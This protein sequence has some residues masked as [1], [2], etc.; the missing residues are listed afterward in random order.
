M[1]NDAQAPDEA[2]PP[3]AD[4]VTGATAPASTPPTPEQLQSQGDAPENLPESVTTSQRDSRFGLHITE[5][6]RKETLLGSGAL[7]NFGAGAAA[8]RALRGPQDTEDKEETK[9]RLLAYKLM[10]PANSAGDYTAAITGHVIGGLMTPEAFL[11]PEIKL[12]T[13]AWRLAH[14]V[15]Q[16]IFGVGT[17]QGL[18]NMATDP[19]VQYHAISAGV[20]EHY[21]W[22]RTAL[23]FPL[24]FVT[25]S[26]FQSLSEMKR[27]LTGHLTGRPDLP[28]VPPAP[29]PPRVWTPEAQAVPVERPPVV[30]PE[31]EIGSSRNQAAESPLGEIRPAEEGA[32]TADAGRTEPGA[33]TAGEPRAEPG[34]SPTATEG[35][36]GAAPAEPARVKPDREAGIEG[37]EVAPEL[38]GSRA[39]T[40]PEIAQGRREPT[41]PEAATTTPGERVE[42]I[43]SPQQAMRRLADSLETVISDEKL[44]IRGAEGEYDTRTAT[45]RLKN[46]T[47][48]DVFTHEIGHHVEYRIGEPLREI[49]RDAMA[50]IGHLVPPELRAQFGPEEMRAEAFAEYMN[51]FLLSEGLAQREAPNFTRS[52]TTFMRERYPGVLLEI[53]QFRA[54]YNAWENA[55][56]GVALKATIIHPT[57][58]AAA[59][60]R[61]TGNPMERGAFGEFLY[62]LRRQLFDRA[63]AMN[64]LVRKVAE[65]RGTI[66]A[67]EDNPALLLRRM[68][69]AAQRSFETDMNV[70]IGGRPHE[71]RV[72]NEMVKFSPN[73]VVEGFTTTRGLY[74]H[75]LASEADSYLRSRRALSLLDEYRNGLR[76][77]RPD[78]GTYADHTSEVARVEAA[79]PEFKNFAEM[80]SVIHADDV[81]RK[82]SGGLITTEQRDALLRNKTYV[83]FQ[84]D[85]RLNEIDLGGATGGPPA[86]QALGA[87]QIQRLV[88]SDRDIISPLSSFVEQMLTTN[89]RLRENEW[90]NS[91][92]RVIRELGPDGAYVGE[93]VPI[94]KTTGTQVDVLEAIGKKLRE[95]GLPREDIDAQL[96]TLRDAFSGADNMTTL[97]RTSERG[98]KDFA[99]TVILTRENGEVKALVLRDTQFARDLH[100]A[101]Q[102]TGK[103]MGDMITRF[104]AHGSNLLRVGATGN[105]TFAVKNLFVD[106]LTRVLTDFRIGRTGTALDF[107]PGLPALKSYAV[108]LNE[109]LRIAANDAFEKI[110][111]ANALFG[112][113]TPLPTRGEPSA[114]D[115]ERALL[116]REGLIGQTYW[117]QAVQATQGYSALGHA[118][119]ETRLRPALEIARAAIRGRERGDVRAEIGDSA[120]YIR[121]IAAEKYGPDAPALGL[122]IA[123]DYVLDAAKLATIDPLKTGFGLF[124]YIAEI[125]EP[126][127]RMA[128][129]REILRYE[130]RAA[131]VSATE[132]RAFY[133][134]PD[135]VSPEV[136]G[137]IIGAIH[138]AVAGSN[139][140]ADF[141][142]SGQ[143]M[144]GLARLTP[145]F[146]ANVQG[147]AA[148]GETLKFLTTTIAPVTRKQ[149]T[150]QQNR[151]YGLWHISALMAGSF[152]WG[153]LKT[154]QGDE[155]Y[156]NTPEWQRLRNWVFPATG[157]INVNIPKPYEYR[158]YMNVAELTGAYLAGRGEFGDLIKGYGA[159]LLDG[160]LPPNPLG[161]GPLSE[162]PHAVSANFDPFRKRAIV[163]ESL[164]KASPVLQYDQ[165]TT[166]AAKLWASFWNHTMEGIGLGDLPLKTRNSVAQ[167]FFSPMMA[168][169]T[170]KAILSGAYTDV[171]G[172]V[173][174]PLSGKPTDI[175]NIPGLRAFV[176]KSLIYGQARSEISENVSRHGG[177][178]TS[179]LVDYRRYSDEGG[180]PQKY[181]ASLKPDQQVYVAIMAPDRRKDG[182]GVAQLHPMERM[183]NVAKVLT[184]VSRMVDKGRVTSLDD[185]QGGFTIS[186]QFMRRDLREALGRVHEL[187]ARNA[188]I[189]SGDSSWKGAPYKVDEVGA[190]YDKIKTLDPRVYEEIANRYATARVPKF[191]ALY[192]PAT[193]KGAW[194]DIVQRLRTEGAG[195]SL[196]GDNADVRASGFELEGTRTKKVTIR[197]VPG[198]VA[199]P[200]AQV[201]QPAAP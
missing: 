136:Q 57:E 127:G 169:Y 189:L 100:E 32:P 124:K 112:D 92:F 132:R 149:E 77:R 40:R 72:N 125:S 107:V 167:V 137:R 175:T 73:D 171:K 65:K 135:S 80:L 120:R 170:V 44:R 68:T 94:T 19:V 195:I 67:A 81:V 199:P 20:Q 26:G 168:D 141:Q 110:E 13:A 91:L 76:D 146:N 160:L 47:D 51:R 27:V 159:A 25:G 43:A 166:E 158:T 61:D 87:K 106:P 101:Y 82:W 41:V 174:D 115:I 130:L 98:P 180:D 74:D 33:V 60:S 7:D 18:V 126:A 24:G 129:A 104:V 139:G 157:D 45:T 42:S 83:P 1:A 188:L 63:E 108:S 177:Q 190:L 114:N 95:T 182:P 12:G 165:R 46:V 85:M 11:L 155:R 69:H 145:F 194:P 23:A 156:Q 172:A 198:A 138:E 163:P 9:D 48:V 78:I 102:T 99:S 154:Q 49:Q 187:E 88:G 118:G 151:L 143:V 147:L 96:G 31:A 30:S 90:S 52:F 183:K 193:G 122:R 103:V 185:P 191:T 35:A 131:G 62:R 105:I 22:L 123:R 15:M 162:I 173:I 111:R 186:D 10:P 6:F 176:S 116:S 64:E 21:E 70:G 71:M 86:G 148:H 28:P 142:R 2:A 4:A 113:H 54:A 97:F 29:E 140:T 196:R 109:F 164:V 5:A 117:Q 93:E 58:L 53:E 133:A 66:V 200:P 17:G 50:E 153:V 197:P 179:A 201:L 59:S 8:R 119:I 150:V 84:R 152:A 39:V 79:Y 3:T 34:A 128:A 16:R 144:T 36:P 134:D 55:P 56:S 38:L 14:P 89:M 192:D 37:G 75:Y 184:D 121:E 178:L 161:A 181:F